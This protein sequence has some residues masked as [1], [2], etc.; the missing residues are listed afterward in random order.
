MT[1]LRLMA[2]TGYDSYAIM[3]GDSFD[4][5]CRES[6][7]IAANYAHC[8]GATSLLLYIEDLE[9]TLSNNNPSHRKID[10]TVD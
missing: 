5:I 3:S 10:I 1:E 8:I 2:Q 9:S 4:K 6:S 7:C